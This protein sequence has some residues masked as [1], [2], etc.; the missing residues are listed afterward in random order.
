MPSAKHVEEAVHNIDPRNSS[1]R[2]ELGTM[3]FIV[4]KI[5]TS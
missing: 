2:L 4:R 1:Q 5:E 3:I